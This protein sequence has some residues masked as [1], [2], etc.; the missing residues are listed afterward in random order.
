MIEGAFG[1]QTNKFSYQEDIF[2][3]GAKLHCR[4]LCWALRQQTI[5]VP[6][7]SV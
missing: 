2:I 6:F 5:N 7:P 3:W 4:T 1:E